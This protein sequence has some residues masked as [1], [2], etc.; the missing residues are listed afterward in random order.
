MILGIMSLVFDLLFFN[1][2][3]YQVN[4][5]A[6]FPMF[7]LVFILK[8]KNIK[9]LFIIFILY[10][11]LIGIIYLPLVILLINYYLTK[12]DLIKNDFLRIIILLILYDLIL[13]LFLNLF[14][15]SLLINKI[16][17]TIPINSLY[18]YFLSSKKI[19][20]QYKLV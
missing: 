17:I 9:S 2:F 8:N 16:F 5:I 13:F 7:S 20:E 11:S 14:D 19:K 3:N 4:N 6:L 18:L 10:S 15:L 1:Y 12:N